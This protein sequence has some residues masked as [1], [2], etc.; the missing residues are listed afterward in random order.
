MLH[1]ARTKGDGS[2]HPLSTIS[3]DTKAGE[4]DHVDEEQ[5]GWG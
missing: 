4:Q 1:P 2:E 3:E 5:K